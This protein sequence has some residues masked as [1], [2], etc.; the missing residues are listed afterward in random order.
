MTLSAVLELVDAGGSVALAVIVWVTLQRGFAAIGTH[1]DG[2]REDMREDRR[3][4][5]DAVQHNGKTL[6]RIDERTIAIVK[7]TRPPRAPASA[8]SGG[9]Q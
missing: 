7:Q 5:V 8:P 1:L 6:A 2:M 4:V 9:S 3:E